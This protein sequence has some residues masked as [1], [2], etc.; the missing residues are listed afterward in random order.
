MVV[1][2]PQ[3]IRRNTLLLAGCMAVYSGAL[4]LSVALATVTFVLVSDI[5]SLLGLGPAIFL[6]AG[7]VA[8][9]VAG[10]AM[11]RFGRVP[12]LAAG[13]CFGI[14][15][16]CVTAAGVHMTST[17]V[18]VLG[19]V[20]I[21]AGNGVISLTRTAGGDMYPPERRARGISFVLFGSVFGA[22]LGPVVFVPIFAGRELETDQLVLPW[23]AAAG[24]LSLG[25]VVSLLV[26]P[27]PRRSPSSSP[28]SRRSTTRRPAR[29]PAS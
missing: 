5:E 11:D 23:I 14:A 20:L 6:S 2:S 1:A 12:V 4:Q 16:N 21:G 15:G 9:L 7:G 19:F 28:S 8:A 27:D 10:R 17:A 13:F 25:L 18:V 26:R 3:Q 29:L 22:I 24:I